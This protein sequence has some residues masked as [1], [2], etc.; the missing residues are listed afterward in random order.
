MK[1]VSSSFGYVFD[2]DA[3]SVSLSSGLGVSSCFLSNSSIRVVGKIEDG[4]DVVVKRV[5]FPT[6]PNGWL[7]RSV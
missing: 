5:F 3:E 7:E 1:I 6:P 2:I 4:F